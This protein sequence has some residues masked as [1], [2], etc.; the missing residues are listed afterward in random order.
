MERTT[1]IE[2]ATLALARRCSTAEPRPQK[3]NAREGTRTP[4]SRTLDPKS[5]ASANSATRACDYMVSHEGLEPST[6]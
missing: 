4:T 6:P 3:I 1:G 2:P 5:S